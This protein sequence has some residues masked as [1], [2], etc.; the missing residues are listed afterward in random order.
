MLIMAKACGITFEKEI[1]GHMAVFGIEFF[2]EYRVC[3][4]RVP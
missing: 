2:Q 4:G 1:P 3:S